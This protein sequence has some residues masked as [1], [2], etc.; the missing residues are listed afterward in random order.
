MVLPILGAI[1]ARVLGSV[2][3]RAVAGQVGKA[4][5]GDIGK[6]VVANT[7]KSEATGLATG[8]SVSQ[9]KQGIDSAR[10]VA[11]TVRTINSAVGQSNNTP[12]QTPTANY[13]QPMSTG[14]SES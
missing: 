13:S 9:M 14:I 8:R 7:A 4:V 12:Q 11:N 10:Q 2:A 1:A 5:A 6:S 3:T